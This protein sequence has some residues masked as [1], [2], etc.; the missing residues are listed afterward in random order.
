MNIKNIEILKKGGVGVIPTDTIYGLACCAFSK[1]VVVRVFKL[2]E[3][4]ENKPLIIII[5]DISDLEK[6]GIKTSLKQAEFIK[7]Y[8]PGKVTVI[9]EVSK[10][11]EYLDKGLG[12][13]IRLP[14][15]EKIR[16][17]LKQTGP[18]ATSSANIQGLPPAKNITEAKK[19]FGPPTGRVNDGVG[20]YE[21]GGE[22]ESLPSTLVKINGDKIEILRQ[23][24][25]RLE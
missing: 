22:L 2:K 14:D 8:W 4:D 19:Y 17:F 9:F 7:K 25:V 16:E 23:G 15:N 12:L 5:S 18:L 13:A 3:R 21:D 11:F 24:I 6:F 1:E 10:E 20:F